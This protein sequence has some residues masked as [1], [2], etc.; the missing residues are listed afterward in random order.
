M[1]LREKVNQ[2]PG[3]AIGAA[4]AVIVLA[5]IILLLQTRGGAASGS[6]SGSG[7]LFFT[8]D[9]GKTWFTDDSTHVPPFMKNG[10][11][12]VR[13]YVYRTRDG[14]KFVGFMERYTPEG[15]KVLEAALARPPEQQTDDPF[16]GVAGALEWKKPGDAAWVSASDPRAEQVVKVVSPKGANDTVSPVSPAQQ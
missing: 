12:A 11:E 16:M 8:T 10:K 4:S 9:D 2:N 3:I 6:A 14:T 7:Q 13:A 1:G 5:G 15:K